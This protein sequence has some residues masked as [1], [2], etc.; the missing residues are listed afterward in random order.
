MSI[1][2][3]TNLQTTQKKP[4][5][6]IILDGWGYAPS[7]GGNAISEA[8]TQN[9]DRLWREFPH[10]TLNASGEAVGLTG[11]ERGNSEVGHLNLGTGQIIKQDLVTI[12]QILQKNGFNDNQVLSELINYTKDQN[13]NIHILSLVSEGGIHSHIDHLF[14]LLDFFS[15]HKDLSNKVFV[16]VITDGRDS[17]PQDALKF[18]S[19]LESKLKQIQIGKI[20]TVSGR[21]YAMDRDQHWERTALVY[22]AITEAKGITANSAL[23]A[24]SHSYNTN[25]KGDEFILPT[26]VQTK[27][28]KAVATVNNNDALIF[29]NFRADRARQITRA[30]TQQNLTQYRRG[31]IIK[32]LFF[33]T[34]VP[35]GVET[36]FKTS[37]IYTL[38]K[39]T[40]IS[41]CLAQ[42]LAKNG[43]TQFH[44]AET[45]KY[46]HVTY[47]FNGGKEKPFIGE[48]RT[49]IPSPR[50]ESY[51]LKPEMS[52]KLI[53]KTTLQAIEKNL[54][55]FLVINYANADMVGHTGKYEAVVKACE[56]IDQQFYQ[57][58]ESILARKG[59]V[60]VTADH[61]NAEQMTNPRT[62]EPDNEHTTNPVPLI[63]VHPNKVGFPKLKT[64]MALSNVAATI[65]YFMNI[66]KPDIMEEKLF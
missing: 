7:W 42:V 17:A 33:C 14:S 50:I 31:K 47:F 51:D 32:N 45:E 55:D 20:A 61:G 58:V 16:H 54:Y 38:F 10:T 21:Y 48:V 8:Q 43:K 19:R 26:V 22:E 49:L 65:L 60:I 3:N 27:E 28:G 62:G 18:V 15:Q 24:I 63:I 1:S 30:F 53:T 29:T 59:I 39:P 37:P 57:I 46:A 4:I 23:S 44:I 2:I 66:E 11:H 34:M 5:A 35:Y 36:E 6:L 52:A 25:N 41:T 64:G 12:N 40:D 9:I 56:E 13:S